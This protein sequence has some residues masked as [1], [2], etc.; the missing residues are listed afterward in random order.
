MRTVKSKPAMQKILLVAS[1]IF[2]HLFIN[3][4]A[5]F[6]YAAD[7][8]HHGGEGLHLH[9]DKQLLTG[10]VDHDHHADGGE[11]GHSL[12][13]DGLN[14]QLNAHEEHENSAHVHL[15]VQLAES[16]LYFILS[17]QTRLASQLAPDYPSLSFSPPVPPPT[18]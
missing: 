5:S 14:S 4:L 16:P 7:L 2:C 11:P 12:E 15:Q 13:T 9:V 18:A 6:H 17:I 1:L 3:S 8:D 10:I